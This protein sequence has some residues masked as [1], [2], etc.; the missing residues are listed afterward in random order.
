MKRV[1]LIEDDP[2][3][4]DAVTD[5]LTDADLQ[6]VRSASGRD[7]LLLFAQQK[8]DLV[9]ADLR[10][11]DL[12]GLAVPRVV[13]DLSRVPVVAT[14]AGGEWRRE[15]FA[16]GA[17]ACLPKPFGI[18]SL[19][20]LVRALLAEKAP[21]DAFAPDVETLSPDDLERVL[22]LSKEE[23]DAL[24]FGLIRLGDDG[25]VLAFNAYEANASGRQRDDVIGKRFED[26]A[27]CVKV[28]RFLSVLTEVREEPGASRVIRFRFPRF[29]AETVVSVRL[30]HDP[31]HGGLWL[32]VSETA[33][34]HALG[35]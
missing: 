35:H 6:V 29:S 11:L 10:V 12:H 31:W 22:S 13:G 28:K 4:A 27:P 9:L 34:G 19:M 17:R 18:E 7:A 23:S 5:V 2:Q 25:T 16:A 26:V 32:F 21:G 33:V 14:S 3:L 24:P 20:S 15:A 1:L 8:V 30:F